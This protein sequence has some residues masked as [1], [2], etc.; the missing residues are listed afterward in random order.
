M[1]RGRSWAGCGWI[2]KPNADLRRVFGRVKLQDVGPPQRLA[3]RLELVAGRRQGHVVQPLARPLVEDQLAATMARL[4]LDSV[5][6]AILL[7]KSEVPVE[8]LPDH[9]IRHFQRVMD[10]PLDW[11]GSLPRRVEV[12]AQVRI[13]LAHRGATR[14]AADG[15]WRGRPVTGSGERRAALDG[16]RQAA[17]VRLMR[18]RTWTSWRR[19][20][21]N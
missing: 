19:D 17:G 4:E 9:R 16:A 12:V 11:H 3:D 14:L 15:R 20:S 21:I 7:L 10:Q 13:T 1:R 5:A 2:V 18:A 6:A 8:R